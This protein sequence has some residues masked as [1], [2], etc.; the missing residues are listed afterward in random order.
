MA[1]LKTIWLKR[2][3]ALAEASPGLYFF[4]TWLLAAFA[5]ASLL[6]F[7]VVTLA[8][9]AFLAYIIANSDISVWRLADWL[10]A[11]AL[12][13]IT[14]IAG[15]LTVVLFK[16]RLP[17][18]PGRELTRQDFK[19]LLDRI[20][21]LALTYRA[22]TIDHVRLTTRF[23]IE[24]QRTPTNG[25]PS[26]YINTLLIGLP[27]M[28]CMSPLHLKLLL[29]RQIGHLASTRKSRKHRLIYLRK[30]WRAYDDYYSVDWRISHL[31]F[32]LLF[33]WF[34]PFF[35]LTTRAAVRLDQFD[36]DQYMLEITTPEKAAEAIA[37]FAVK[38]HYLEHEFWPQLNNMAFTRAKPAWLPYSSMDKIIDRKLSD[39]NAQ[40]IY[41]QELNRHPQPGDVYANLRQRLQA[42]GVEDFVA[43]ERKT[44]TAAAHFLGDSLTAVQKQLDN[45]WYLR[46]KSVWSLRYKKGLE[47]KEQLKLLR[48]QA[49][50]ALLSNEE[51][52][53]YLLLLEKYVDRKK[54]LPLYMEILETN[55]LDAGVCYELG[56]LMLEADYEGGVKALHMAME[57]DADYTVDCCQHIVKYMANH[58]DMKQA[59]KYRRMILAHQVEN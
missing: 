33:S 32:R 12:L 40:L 11:A 22:P 38:K 56:R 13:V 37:M 35:E 58:G 27:V 50:Q 1:F 15:G 53:H 18:P 28:S 21:E 41:E 44:E 43:P 4:F 31:P 16:V 20:D 2:M 51:A 49:A 45:V 36:K 24:I 34:N 6:L 19:V 57:L 3:D 8:A 46:N 26:R 47:E 9:P 7:P 59:Q 10:L 54:A 5:F 39:I 23:E 25:F 29:A 30:V 52:K 55:A 17:P 42:F 14:L 48:K